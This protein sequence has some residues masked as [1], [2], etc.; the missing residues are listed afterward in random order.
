MR[1]KLLLIDSGRPR[2]DICLPRRA[3][4]AE[5]F[6]AEE[7]QSHLLRMT[8]A[9]L[10]LVNEPR[11]RP[12]IFV[13]RGK[14]S[15]PL[16]GDFH[17]AEL[18][19]DGILLRREGKGLLLAG[20][21]PRGTLYA[22]YEWLEL[23]GCRWL[24]AQCSH[25]PS[26]SIVA[27]E[28]LDLAYRPPFWFRHPRFRSWAWYGPMEADWAARNRVNGYSTPLEDRHGGRC[29]YAGPSSHSFFH[30]LPPDQYFAEHPEFYSLVDGR[31]MYESAQLCLTNPDVVDALAE[32]CRR[33]LRANP[34]A[35]M[36][37]I[38]QMDAHD[39]YCHCPSCAQVD[40]EEGSHAGTLVRFVN[41]VAERLEAEFP[42]VVFTTLAYVYT[43]VPP[44][45]TRP[46]RNVCVRL[47]HMSC[48][49][50]DGKMGMACEAHPIEACERNTPFA[51][52]VRKWMAISSHVL[53]WDYSTDF[54]QYFMPFPNLDAII[55]DLKFFAHSGIGGVYCQGNGAGPPGVPDKGPGDMGDLRAYLCAKLLWRPEQDGWKIVDEFLRL[56]YRRSARAIRAYLD[57][58][59]E[60]LRGGRHH[61]HM[62]ENLPMSLFTPELLAQADEC[63]RQA[64][65]AA[66]NDAELIERV[67]VAFLALD[68]V[69][70]Q[71]NL[72]FV[73]DG[74]RWRAGD[75]AIV[76]RADRFFALAGKH[77]ATGLHEW[78]PWLP[79]CHKPLLR[80]VDAHHVGD[81]RLG[82]AVAAEFGGRMMELLDAG[83]DWLYHARPRDGGFPCHGGYAETCG[84]VGGGESYRCEAGGS[85]LTLTADLNGGLRALRTIAL[86]AGKARAITIEST[87]T[88]TGSA[89]LPAQPVATAKF[90]AGNWRTLRLRVR[91]ADGT[92]KDLAPWRK[93]REHEGALEFK[94]A[95]LSAGALAVCRGRRQLV[96][97]FQAQAYTLCRVLWN[98]L[99]DSIAVELSTRSRELAPQEAME[100]RQRWILGTQT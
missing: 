68:F 20:N 66:G 75:E 40:E 53:V 10:E 16:A 4:P 93:S 54:A 73:R 59:H 89:G 69:Q 45:H 2:C 44:R 78:Q 64:L 77:G 17:W 52:M 49:T 39:R 7:L 62:Y 47:C 26:L 8:G 27:V 46:R 67:Q 37:D 86:E 14:A 56:Y 33:I 13:G 74:R 28:K 90:D 35:C 48:P 63:K 15:E 58:L 81:E 55:A 1:D 70:W 80:R 18:G 100:L 88:N 12:T 29:E 5:R 9:K 51:D 85:S 79:E 6:A 96:W 3:H 97:E 95:D 42:R 94:E 61:F 57:L 36:M 65:A 91:R 60:P 82:V 31:R 19:E 21:S 99:T 43:V 22:V 34:K 83:E 41:A 50:P 24:T 72:R 30:L 87:W 25:V 98:R 71:Y 76:Q 32:R 23:L 11:R 38:S 84:P 92:W